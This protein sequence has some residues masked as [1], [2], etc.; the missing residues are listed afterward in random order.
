MN[1]LR[2]LRDNISRQCQLLEENVLVNIFESM[3]GRVNLCVSF[4]LKGNIFSICCNNLSKKLLK[5]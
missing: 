3:K 2:N 4:I 5:I 1:D